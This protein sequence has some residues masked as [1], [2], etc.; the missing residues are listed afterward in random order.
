MSAPNEINI[1][2]RTFNKCHI[3]KQQWE[4]C[5]T[6]CTFCHSIVQEQCNLSR[7]NFCDDCADE[8]VCYIDLG[9]IYGEEVNEL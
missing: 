9:A 7:E 4:D 6:P 1:K 5:I 8:R 3:S 2:G